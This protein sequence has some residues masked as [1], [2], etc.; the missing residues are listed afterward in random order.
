MALG[1]HAF[2][3]LFLGKP[4]VVGYCMENTV[5][6]C[7]AAAQRTPGGKLSFLERLLAPHRV[8]LKNQQGSLVRCQNAW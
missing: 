5:R 3:S 4:K 8:G 7:T 2:N 6:L 1:I